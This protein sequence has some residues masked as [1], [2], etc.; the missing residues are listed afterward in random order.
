MKNFVKL[1]I[2]GPNEQTA[3]IRVIEDLYFIGYP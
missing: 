1:M 3:V 2:E